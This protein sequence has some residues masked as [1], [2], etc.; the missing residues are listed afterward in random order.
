[1]TASASACPGCGGPM[2]PTDVF[3]C[4]GCWMER[5]TRGAHGPRP[6]FEP[7]KRKSRAP[8]RRWKP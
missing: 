3:E 7:I 1:M 6:T 2:G 8:K 4:R 5:V